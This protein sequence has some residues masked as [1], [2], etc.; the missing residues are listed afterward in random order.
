M[1]TLH[2]TI[3]TKVILYIYKIIRQNICL[4]EKK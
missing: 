2:Y 4:N 3:D 1:G